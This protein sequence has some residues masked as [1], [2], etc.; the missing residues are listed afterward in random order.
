MPEENEAAHYWLSEGF[1]DFLTGRILV[2]EGVWTPAQFAADLNEALAA[3]AQSPGRTA[4]NER[5]AAEFWRDREMQRLPY[6]RGR[7]LASIWDARLRA[8]GHDLDDVVLEMRARAAAGDPH[9]AAAMF[10]LVM[11]GL[12]LDVRADIEAF[13]ERGEAIVLPE[14]VFAPCGRVETRQAY[15]FHRGFSIEATQANNNVISGLDPASPAYAAGMRDGMVLL[16]REGGEIGN[17]D[18]E[19]GYVV[20]DGEAER[21]FRYMPRGGDTFPLQQ[22]VLAENLSGSQLA[23]CAAVL[24]GV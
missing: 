1:T 7:M 8:R 12:G 14:D 17:A 4:P 16:R 24:S 13:V 20:R 10:P 3:Y 6:Q 15:A 19:I 5:V 21:T 9:K 23:Q 11:E 18:L 2:R 22:L